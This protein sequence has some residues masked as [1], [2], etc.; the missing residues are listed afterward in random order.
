MKIIEQELIGLKENKKLSVKQYNN[1]FNFFQERE[2]TIEDN[3]IDLIPIFLNSIIRDKALLEQFFLRAIKYFFSNTTPVSQ[4]DAAFFFLAALKKHKNRE[5]IVECLEEYFSVL[6]KKIYEDPFDL[7][8][9]LYVGELCNYYQTDQKEFSNRIMMLDVILSNKNLD[10]IA[11]LIQLNALVK[12]ML[13]N[14]HALD[15]AFYFQEKMYFLFDRMLDKPAGEGNIPLRGHEDLL[16]KSKAT[17]ERLNL[18]IEKHKEND[19]VFNNK[20]EIIDYLSSVLKDKEN[21]ST[22]LT[23]AMEIF[24]SDEKFASVAF[25]FLALKVNSEDHEILLNCFMKHAFFLYEEIKNKSEKKES[26][27]KN[28]YSQYLYVADLASLYQ[29]DPLIEFEIR[30]SILHMILEWRIPNEAFL[31]ALNQLRQLID[32]YLSSSEIYKEDSNLEKAFFLEYQ[33]SFFLS[34][35]C[36]K[37]TQVKEE[38]NS[39]GQLKEYIKKEIGKKKFQDIYNKLQMNKIKKNV[40]FYDDT[41]NDWKIVDLGD[42]NYKNNYKKVIELLIESIIQ[43]EDEILFYCFPKIMEIFFSDQKDEN[44]SKIAYEFLENQETRIKNK[45]LKYLKILREEME[46][47]EIFSLSE[48]LCV[49]NLIFSYQN[50]PIIKSEEALRALS[51]FEENEKKYAAEIANQYGLLIQVYLSNP[52]YFTFLKYPTEIYN[53]IDNFLKKFENHQ[54]REKLKELGKEIK[55]REKRVAKE[56]FPKPKK[57]VER[58]IELIFDSPLVIFNRRLKELT[59]SENKKS[60][61]LI[62]LIKLY[63]LEIGK[64]DASFERLIILQDLKK[65]CPEIL[66]IDIQKKWQIFIDEKVNELKLQGNEGFKKKEYD[67][68]LK[69]YEKSV[70]INPDFAIGYCNIAQCYFQKN[71]LEKALKYFYLAH[72]KDKKYEKPKDRIVECNKLLGNACFEKKEYKKAMIFYQTALDADFSRCKIYCISKESFQKLSEKEFQNIYIC[73]ENTLYFYNRHEKRREKV[74]F[75]NQELGERTLKSILK[76]NPSQLTIEL[77]AKQF[78]TLITNN[79]LSFHYIHSRNPEIEEKITD[80]EV[81]ITNRNLFHN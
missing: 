75:F 68:A 77:D 46:K 40:K 26:L 17:L 35:D 34:L 4:N 48:Y 30:F 60:E 12:Y 41:F 37:Y 52:S 50:N 11:A 81:G 5:K 44:Q 18:Y 21:L 67:E 33:L 29:F 64:D 56:D 51:F 74:K 70:R 72:E 10:E 1:I 32:L 19:F 47:K 78:E 7:V 66:D 63:L 23:K 55:Q 57:K 62:F 14:K 76:N 73:V 9:Y 6:N 80:C 69:F 65:K 49:I 38:K 24:F 13:D 20:A 16:I 61:D 2:Y 71:D 45:L 3:V 59:E 31:A 8:E 36:I 15:K 39:L 27:P 58:K 28:L 79:T 43:A 54:L 22:R 25:A 53:K 42:K